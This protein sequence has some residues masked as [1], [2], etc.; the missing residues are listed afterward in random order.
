M[1]I[2]GLIN[3]VGLVGAVFVGVVFRKIKKREPTFTDEGVLIVVKELYDKYTISESM[4]IFFAILSKI[5]YCVLFITN[6]HQVTAITY[7][8][9]ISV[10]ILSLACIC[11]SMGIELMLWLKY[12]V[13]IVASGKASGQ[14]NYI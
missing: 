14:N 4:L 12:Q 1:V 2:L 6:V 7:N 8:I 9:L 5:V 13:R 10:E 11:G 3:L